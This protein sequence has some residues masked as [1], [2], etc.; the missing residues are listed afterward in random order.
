[1]KKYNYKEFI[2]KFLP[3]YVVCS[4][5]N[6]LVLKK[7]AIVRDGKNF[8]SEKHAQHSVQRTGCGLGKI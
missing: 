7:E 3:N 6:E 1:M 4:Y 2:K 5:C 8:C